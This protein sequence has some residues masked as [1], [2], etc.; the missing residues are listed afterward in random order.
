LIGGDVFQ[1]FI[2]ATITIG[3]WLTLI[4]WVIGRAVISASV[5]VQ[6]DPGIMRCEAPAT[7]LHRDRRRRSSASPEDARLWGPR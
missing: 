3:F 1:V 7:D 5:R 4:A 2:I 6:D